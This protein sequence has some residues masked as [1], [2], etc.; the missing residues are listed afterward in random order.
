MRVFVF[1][2]CAFLILPHAAEAFQDE[3]VVTGS[4]I[5]RPDAARR[6]PPA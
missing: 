1:A 5:A 3:I 4:R 6:P 2:L